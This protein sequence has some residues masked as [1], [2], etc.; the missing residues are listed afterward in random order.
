[1]KSSSLLLSIVTAVAMTFGVS[2]SSVQAQCTGDVIPS[3]I[4]DGVDLAQILSSW[5]PCTNCPA[6]ID[7]DGAVTG[8]DLGQMLAGWGPCAP[9]IASVAPGQGTIV[10]GT[11]ITISGAYFTGATS[12]TIGGALAT[13]MVVVSSTT[14]TAVTPAHAAGSVSIT[15]TT[16]SRASTFQNAFVYASSSILSIVPNTG[17]VGGGALITISGSYLG[18]ATS[19][20]IGGA[21]AT[22][23]IVVSPTTITAVTPTG[24]LGPA[25]VVVT[26]PAGTLTSLNGFSYVNIIVPTWATLLEASPD[27][28]VVTD[29]NLRA[30]I[31]TS[32]FA[33]RIKDTSSNIEMLLVPAGTFTMGCSASNSYACVS[34]ESPTHQVTLTQAFY[35]GRYEV[36]QAQ[37]TAKM[38]NNPSYFQGT[39]NPDAANRPVERVS[40]DMI[41]SG[42]TSFMSLTGLRLPTE[43]EWEYAYRAATTTAFHGFPGYTSGTNEDYQLGNI[44]WYQG[45]GT[46]PVGGKFANG[47]GLHDMAG[48]VFEWC[49][50][51]YGPYSSAS[52]TN[53]TG[54]ATGPYRLLRGGT[55][56]NNSYSLRAS[57]R[58]VNNPSDAG[59]GTGFRVARTP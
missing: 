30:A 54:P 18:G 1:M 26:T 5:G 32:G 19:V 33:W 27:P 38:G 35:M 42:S 6:D 25:D 51:W 40:W 23:L 49:Q 44:A 48:N 41:A 10:G 53:P 34:G 39:S 56:D 46:R 29:V 28:T 59:N 31:V 15:I 37:W 58:D 9:F 24:T 36:T 43:A 4:I 47:L 21:P 57:Q 2:T 20:T 13:N 16:P 17:V 14:I 45:G 22:N 12:V 11:P 3:G 50:D 7:G 52:V 8:I 55:W